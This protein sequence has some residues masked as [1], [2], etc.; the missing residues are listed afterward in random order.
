M[1]VR[2]TPT[3]PT[4][5]AGLSAPGAVTHLSRSAPADTNSAECASTGRV[6]LWNDANYTGKYSAYA[7]QVTILP[8][9]SHDQVSSF[10]NRYSQAWV[11]YRDR[12]FVFPL[13]C[14]FP[15][16]KIADL[17][18]KGANDTISSLRR[19]GSTSCPAGI[20]TV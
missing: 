20:P 15:G 1:N 4:I 14:V 2:S 9:A 8:P 12:D 5:G 19:T 7:T 16:H 17:G 6:C 18:T 13:L 3:W 11:L 10:W